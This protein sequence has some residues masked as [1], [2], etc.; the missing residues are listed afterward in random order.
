MLFYCIFICLWRYRYRYAACVHLPCPSSRN[1][2]CW[3]GRAA[4]W[5]CLHSLKSSSSYTYCS[6][7]L[8]YIHLPSDLHPLVANIAFVQITQ[9]SH[10]SSNLPVSQSKEVIMAASFRQMAG[11]PDSTASVNDSVLVIIDA[12]NEYAEGKSEAS[13]SCRGK[14]SS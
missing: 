9:T 8:F 13:L 5:E 1:L 4:T 3:N 14:A 6:S 12:Q 7:R 2:T 10:P 11:I